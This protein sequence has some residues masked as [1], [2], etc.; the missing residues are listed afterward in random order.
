ML[1]RNESEFGSAPVTHGALRPVGRDVR[2]KHGA[3]L[4]NGGKLPSLSL[5]QVKSLLKCEA[6]LRLLIQSKGIYVGKQVE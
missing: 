1:P 2:L 6:V 4:P 3:R 5:H